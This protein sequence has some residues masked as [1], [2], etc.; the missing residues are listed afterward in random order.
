MMIDLITSSIHLLFRVAGLHAS[1]MFDYILNYMQFHTHY[2]HYKLQFMEEFRYSSFVAQQR[3]SGNPPRRR[4]AA[5][6]SAAAHPAGP[7]LQS[8]AAAQTETVEQSE[9]VGT[10]RNK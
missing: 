7:A 1:Y 3:H 8:A 9:Q 4:G 6:L 5:R 2:M 10:S